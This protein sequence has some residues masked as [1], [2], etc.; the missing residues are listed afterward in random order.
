MKSL[1][2]HLFIIFLA[3]NLDAYANGMTDN[4]NT[5]RGNIYQTEGHYGPSCR[6]VG[7][8]YFEGNAKKR[9]TF[10]IKKVDGNDDVNTI[11]LTAMISNK[12]VEIEFEEGVT[13]GCGS[14]PAIQR[15]KLFK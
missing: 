2:T 12:E 9:R 7:L 10:R 3:F 8:E 11:V 15:V 4:T 1:K 6:I 14:Q 13:S 5:L